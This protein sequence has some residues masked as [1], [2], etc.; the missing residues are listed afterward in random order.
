MLDSQALAQFWGEVG[1]H[2]QF[3][4]DINFDW[5]RQCLS[6]DAKILD[7]GCGYGRLMKQLYDNGYH[8]VTGLDFAKEMLVKGA[9]YFPQG[10]FALSEHND[11]Q[12]QDESLDAIIFFTVLNCIPKPEEQQA[13]VKRFYQDLKKG[14]IVYICDYL[15]G[16][17]E[18]NI[19]RYQTF[20][21]KYQYMGTFE[22][23]DGACVCRH[24][25]QDWIETLFN[26]FTL[27]HFHIH[28]NA[29][30]MNGNPCRRFQA[31]YM[32]S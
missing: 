12:A 9:Q 8:H 32:K 3:D 20:A 2:K 5:L 24:H 22:I 1:A 13:L 7:Y 6:D 23:A 30:T 18:R 10:Q 19:K 11:I 26:D 25:P 21:K 29:I 4:E 28:D 31:I 15:L 16:T 14:G 27:K 17:D